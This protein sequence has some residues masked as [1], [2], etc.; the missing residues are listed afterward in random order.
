VSG[1]LSLPFSLDWQSASP[2]EQAFYWAVLAMFAVALVRGACLARLL[3]KGSAD[4]A[5]DRLARAWDHLAAVRGLL[6]L[7]LLV[8]LLAA[9]S[10]SAGSFF[11][12]V[13]EPDGW[14][15]LDATRDAAIRL[16]LMLPMCAVIGAI[17][18]V[19]DAALQRRASGSR[20]APPSIPSRP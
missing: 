13:S 11:S 19:F 6:C 8:T 3:F 18:I 4:H 15:M 2:V 16:T 5:S 17:W 10:A 12:Y 1:D 14:A 7:A 20:S 9:A